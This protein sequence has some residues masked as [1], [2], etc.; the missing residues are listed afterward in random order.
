MKKMV[1]IGLLIVSSV[2]TA[3]DAQDSQ[4]GI[5]KSIKFEQAKKNLLF[6]WAEA[7]NKTVECY[8]WTCNTIE[9][10]KEPL[11]EKLNTAGRWVALQ[12]SSCQNMGRR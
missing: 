10:N 3:S 12:I 11:K 4:A 9:N 7:K 5:T 2:C 8:N 6:A 1:L